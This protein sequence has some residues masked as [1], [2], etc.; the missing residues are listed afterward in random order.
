MIIGT[1]LLYIISAGQLFDES[2]TTSNKWLGRF[3]LLNYMDSM[4]GNYISG[5]SNFVIAT[6]ILLALTSIVI[7]LNTLEYRDI[8]EM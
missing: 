8:G 2:Y 7:V 5:N 6:I 4:L 1:L 3:S